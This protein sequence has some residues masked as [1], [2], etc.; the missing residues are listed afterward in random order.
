MWLILA[1]FPPD[2]IAITRPTPATLSE[3]IPIN[4][5]EILRKEMG[6]A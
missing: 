5:H 6:K 4:L 2:L 1:V 3:G